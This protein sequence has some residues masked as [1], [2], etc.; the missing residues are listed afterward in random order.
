MSSTR[1]A[2]RMRIVEVVGLVLIPT[3]LFVAAWLMNTVTIASSVVSATL[4]WICTMI[5]IV[6]LI[7]GATCLILQKPPGQL[8]RSVAL[9]ICAATSLGL[10]VGMFVDY[11]YYYPEAAIGV[12]LMEWVGFTL[13]LCIVF[14]VPRIPSRGA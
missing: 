13:I 10:F 14:F 9:T 7:L 2:P 11:R 4:P 6:L 3:A 8:P 5:G 12:E 1:Q